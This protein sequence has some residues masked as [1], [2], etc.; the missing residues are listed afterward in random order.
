VRGGGVDYAEIM[1]VTDREVSGKKLSDEELVR[2]LWEECVYPGHNGAHY[3][4]LYRH[5]K[6]ENGIDI[7]WIKFFLDAY[8]KCPSQVLDKFCRTLF[9][10]TDK[11]TPRQIVEAAL[12][13]L[14]MNR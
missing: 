5:C 8:C 14:R 7:P 11:F 12:I 9:P 10:D 3:I 13:Y 2:E 1:P 4:F 6:P